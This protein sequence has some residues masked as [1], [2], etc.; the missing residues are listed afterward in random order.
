MMCV[1]HCADVTGGIQ[2]RYGAERIAAARRAAAG[3]RDAAQHRGAR[4]ADMISSIRRLPCKVV[5]P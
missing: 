5:M 4:C 2:K 1:L 3:Q